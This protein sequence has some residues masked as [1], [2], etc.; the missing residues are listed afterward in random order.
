MDE[1]FLE[2]AYQ[3]LRII[4]E[5]NALTGKHMLL[6]PAG[7]HILS[8][9]EVLNPVTGY[10]T[11]PSVFWLVGGGMQETFYSGTVKVP[12]FSH[13]ECKLLMLAMIYTLPTICTSMFMMYFIHCILTNMWLKHIGENIMNEV[14]HKQLTPF[15]SY[16]YIIDLI[17]AGNMELILML[18]YK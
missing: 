1:M 4:M 13:H 5:T 6:C 7:E 12:R 11:G 10:K 14:H 9:F 2:N 8:L 3:L 17:N 18:Y 16:L 15:V